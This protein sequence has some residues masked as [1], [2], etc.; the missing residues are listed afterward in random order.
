L[1]QHASTISENR[2]NGVALC[3][4]GIGQTAGRLGI[5]I[6]NASMK[7]AVQTLDRR[8][9]RRGTHVAVLITHFETKRLYGSIC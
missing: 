1:Y 8:Q 5:M 4:D 2:L 3:G 9:M 6:G 7:D